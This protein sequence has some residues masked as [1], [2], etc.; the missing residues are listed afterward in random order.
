L[1]DVRPSEAAA[2][3]KEA[4]QPKE[5]NK[6]PISTSEIKKEKVTELMTIV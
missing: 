4:V 6:Y 3:L 1:L 2:L 5:C